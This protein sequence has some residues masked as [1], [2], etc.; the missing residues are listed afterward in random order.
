ML[1]S[2]AT[3]VLSLAFV[4]GCSAP[5]SPSSGGSG[6]EAPPPPSAKCGCK[7]VAGKCGCVHCKGGTDDPT[8]CTCTSHPKDGCACACKGV[9]RNCLCGHCVTGGGK[10]NCA[11]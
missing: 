2:F 6:A 10:C 9:A 1:K 11:K 3:L 8:K 4:W 7:A 5:G